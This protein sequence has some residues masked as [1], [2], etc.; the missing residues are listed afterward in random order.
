M[1]RNRRIL[2]SDQRPQNSKSAPPAG[3]IQKLPQPHLHAC[4]KFGVESLALALLFLRCRPLAAQDKLLPVFHFNRLT[5]ADGFPSNE[6]RSNVVR[7]PQGFIWVGTVD[8]LVRYDGYSCKVYRN[9]P[10]NPHSLSSNSVITLHVDRKGRL[11]VGTS[12]TGLSLYDPSKDR[13][14][15][16]L[17]RRADSLWFQGHYV[18]YIM[19][20]GAGPLWIGFADGQAVR[21]DLG[22]ALD[23]THPDSVARHAKFPEHQ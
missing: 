7:D 20:D 5:T 16:F 10:G 8:G 12:A 13:F 21:L 22:S 15:N 19:E 11:W 18:G 9:Q 14:V 6:M 1:V 3:A 17:P 2:N 23:D 4:R